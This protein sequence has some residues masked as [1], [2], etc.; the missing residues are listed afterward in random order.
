MPKQ[1]AFQ[2]RSDLSTGRF[3]KEEGALTGLLF[4]G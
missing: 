4:R 1:A 3:R 2:T